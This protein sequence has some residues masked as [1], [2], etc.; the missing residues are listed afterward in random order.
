MPN[1]PHRVSSDFSPPGYSVVMDMPARTLY[2][3]FQ[4]DKSGTFNLTVLQKLLRIIYKVLILLYE[5]SESPL[6][7]PGFFFAERL[8]KFDG[9][10]VHF[11]DHPPQ[12]G[13]PIS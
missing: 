11:A 10:A 12:R 6:Y 13:F 3:T 1:F 7:L 8:G 2:L 4:T 9:S 5:E